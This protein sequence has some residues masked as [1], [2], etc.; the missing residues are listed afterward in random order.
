MRNQKINQRTF[1]VLNYIRTSD[2]EIDDEYDGELDVIY[3]RPIEFKAHISGARGTSQVE[4]FGDDIVY[5]KTILISKD[6]FER[7]KITEQS[8]F[9]IDKKPTYKGT[10]PL[11]DYRVKRLATTINEVA[12]ALVKV[13]QNAN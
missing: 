12:I 13:G 2:I 7:L 9:F 6:K 11:Y 5:D 3:T 1:Y 4:M 8:V 10:T